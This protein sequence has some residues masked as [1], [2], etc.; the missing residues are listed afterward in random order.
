LK[1]SSKLKKTGR[2]D[3]A[4]RHV[5]LYHWFMET[6]AWKSLEVV[7]RALYIEILA[8]Y[9]GPGTNNGSIPYSV[10][11]AAERLHIGKSTAASSFRRLEEKGFVV[12][13]Q[14]GGFTCKIR[15]SSEW[16]LTEFNCDQTG[17]LATKEFARWSPEKQKSV[18]HENRSVPER[19]QY[20]IPPRT[21]QLKTAGNGI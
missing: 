7:D 15:H 17:E 16:R 10:R 13:T 21:V 2:S 12:A 20:D 3:K 9:A 14:K 18:P 19:G 8:R 5:R 11:E 6:L 1:N 4:P